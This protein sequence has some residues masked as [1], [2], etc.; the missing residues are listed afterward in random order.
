MKPRYAAD[1]MTFL[2]LAF[3]AVNLGV[4]W[5][6]PQ[7]RSYL[8]PLQC[9]LA[10]TAGIIAHNHNHCPTF[11]NRRANDVLNH[12]ATLF[13]GFAAFNWIPTHNLNH[14]KFQNA[15]GDATITWRHSKKH[16]LVTALS[17]PFI[18]AAMQAPL[19]DRYVKE[20]KTKR[21]AQY[22][23]IM[24]QLI[25]CWGLPIALMF[26]DWRS[27]LITIGIPRLFSL[28][29]IIYFN[30]GQHIHCDPYSK[31]N[32]ARNFTGPV[33]NFLLFNN[34]FHTVHH[35]K[36]GAHWSL[37]PESH[38]A[39]AAN[40]HPDLNQRNFWVWAFKCYVLALFDSKYGTQQI[41][42]APYDPPAEEQQVTL[43]SEEELEPA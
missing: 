30:Y 26:V 25:I 3:A 13:Y 40:I 42:R 37:A 17:Y 29:A 10:L 27:T 39:V 36:A 34:G 11:K 4:I 2:W 1:Y 38:A 31:W 33:L 18:S 28:F 19:I 23:S 41:G 21:P 5:H 43:G 8:V 20:S 6:F 22:R 16:N 35:M 9:Y 32:H 7:T 15:P 24:I 14:H 12:I